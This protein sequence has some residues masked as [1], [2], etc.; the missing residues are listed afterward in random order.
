MQQANLISKADTSA[1]AETTSSAQSTIIAFKL[2]V[3]YKA[4]I[5]TADNKET[6]TYIAWGYIQ[7]IQ[8]KIPELHRIIE[9]QEISKRN[10]GNFNAQ[11]TYYYNHP[12]QT[13]PT[14]GK[15]L[16]NNIII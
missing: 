9:Q 5:M 11:L 3:A 8:E 6:K 16:R 4:E 10:R 2:N 7:R 13:L 14:H 12:T 15:C 1:T